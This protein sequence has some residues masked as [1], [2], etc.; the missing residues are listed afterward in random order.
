MLPKRFRLNEDHFLEAV[1]RRGRRIRGRF[2]E[3]LFLPA[4]PAELRL[5][6]IVRKTIDKRSTRRNR[7]RR[8]LNEAI[9]L[10]IPSLKTGFRFLVY[11]R[12]A[13]LGR[14][15]PEIRNDLFVVLRE[16]GFFDKPA[17]RF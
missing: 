17:E 15:L 1:K 2:S 7:F 11:G 12:K 6:F 4:A 14:T 8:L 5:A 3:L 13:G 9:S 10:A 16:G